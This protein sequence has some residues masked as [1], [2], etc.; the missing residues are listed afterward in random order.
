MKNLLDIYARKKKDVAAI[1]RELED[2]VYSSHAMLRETSLN[3][4][5]AGGKRS[6]PAFV[7]LA[8]EFGT[9][10]L[11][12]MKHIAVTLELIHMA[13]LVHDDIIDDAHTR[14]GQLTVRS[15]WDN[16]SAMYT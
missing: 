5:K 3:L 10:N 8:G 15:K 2:S 9:Y 13:T 7:L 16:R 14:R 1:E 4:L 11:E 6:R 12:T